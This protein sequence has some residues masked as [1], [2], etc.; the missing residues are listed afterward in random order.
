MIQKIK[1][2]KG[3]VVKVVTGDDKGKTGK[4]LKVLPSRNRAVVEGLNTMKKHRRARR[5]SEKGEIVSV[6]MPMHI[7][8][9]KLDK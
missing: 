7:S 1:I 4:V 8:N 9:L 2:K 3:D 6:A 5:T